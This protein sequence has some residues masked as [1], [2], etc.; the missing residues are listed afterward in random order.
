MNP[1]LCL[2]RPPRRMAFLIALLLAMALQRVVRAECTQT[3]FG[4]ACT[5]GTAPAVQVATAPV[6]PPAPKPFVPAY[7]KVT[8]KSPW[9]EWSLN[10]W[11]FATA[12]TAETLC[13]RLQCAFVRL[14]PCVGSGGPFACDQQERWLVF[15]VDPD[16]GV[17][18]EENAGL[19]ASTYT[20]NPEDKFPGLADK[21]VA[22]IL[23]QDRSYAK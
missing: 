10:E 14:K 13:R 17:L 21:L 1:T 15:K 12:D 6:A 23:A 5:P 16:G 7:E 20:R 4:M 18:F 8:I 2:F 19:L 22:M 3:P 9:G 11:Y